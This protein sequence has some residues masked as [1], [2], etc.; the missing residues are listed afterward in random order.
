[1]L[2]KRQLRHFRYLRLHQS[3]LGLV[4]HFRSVVITPHNSLH[5]L[6]ISDFTHQASSVMTYAAKY[7][8]NPQ[9]KLGIVL[10]AYGI[11]ALLSPLSATAFSNSNHW[12]FHYFVSL[13]GTVLSVILLIL[14]F[15]FDS[16]DGSS[17][18]FFVVK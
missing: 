13:G 15:R 14:V 2:F 12:S 4:S 10:A 6:Q 16:L 1:M 7:N 8:K 11:G 17:M 5:R 9:L 18:L 3:S